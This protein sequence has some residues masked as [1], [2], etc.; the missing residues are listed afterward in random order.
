MSKPDFD[1]KNKLD[2]LLNEV[3]MKGMLNMQISW[4]RL[5]LDV[6]SPCEDDGW[7]WLD[8]LQSLGLARVV[9]DTHKGESRVFAEL[10]PAGKA[11]LAHMEYGTRGSQLELEARAR[12]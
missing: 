11:L 4:G 1:S 10:T 3:V 2:H 6:V 5:R 12:E 8:E 9:V 7:N